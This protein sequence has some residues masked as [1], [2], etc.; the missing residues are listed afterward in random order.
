MQTLATKV[1]RSLVLVALATCFA[2]P[3]AAAPPDISPEHNAWARFRRGSWRTERV[4]TETFDEHGEVVNST[5]MTTTTELRRANRRSIVLHEEQT[6]KNSGREFF[7]R[8][9]D[10]EED[11]LG[12]LV[13]ESSEFEDHGPTTVSIDGRT[14][15]CRLLTQTTTDRIV[16]KTE[17]VY[18]SQDAS[19]FVLKLVSRLVDRQSDK[20]VSTT[21]HEVEKL[22]RE[23]R[24]IGVTVDTSRARTFTTDQRGTTE[25]EIVFSMAIP[26]GVVSEIT[27]EKNAAGDLVRRTTV[28]LLAAGGKP[29]LFQRR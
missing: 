17:Q 28:E 1:F 19:P 2:Q 4:V 3:V 26:G 12:R 23:M 16:R 27:T 24:V 9:Q 15:D 7:V 6:L 22:D 13:G 20:T 29:R 10:V 11:F 5:E 14:I 18:Y 21:T 8:R 25:T